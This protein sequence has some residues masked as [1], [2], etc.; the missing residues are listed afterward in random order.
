MV[1]ALCKGLDD[2]LTG[3][4]LMILPALLPCRRS[5]GDD[6]RARGAAAG[7]GRTGSRPGRPSPDPGGMLQ[8]P[9]RAPLAGVGTA[10]EAAPPAT[11]AARDARP[12]R[13]ISRPPCLEICPLPFPVPFAA[14]ESR[15]RLP[16]SSFSSSHSTSRRQPDNVLPTTTTTT[17]TTVRGRQCNHT[18]RRP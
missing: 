14:H 1:R 9:E 8:S 15:R 17:T 6:V 10:L 13:A 2:R 18:S 16:L 12:R 5:H 3:V 11:S 7:A 4:A